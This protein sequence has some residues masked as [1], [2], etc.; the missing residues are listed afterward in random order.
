VQG[1]AR[2]RTLPISLIW[3]GL[4]SL[5]DAVTAVDESGASARTDRNRIGQRN[6]VDFHTERTSLGSKMPPHAGVFDLSGLN[7][8]QRNF[9][10]HDVYP[11]G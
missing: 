10:T 3:S 2:C 1:I 7:N 4:G 6:G 5:A 11:V 9:D 8:K